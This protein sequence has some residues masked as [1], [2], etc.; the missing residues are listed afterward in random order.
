VGIKSLKDLANSAPQKVAEP[1]N[2]PDES[3]NIL[4]NVEDS[5]TKAKLSKN[6]E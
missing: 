1:F 5:L 3:A 6:L 4:V 2:I